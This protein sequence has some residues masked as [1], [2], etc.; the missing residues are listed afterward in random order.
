MTTSAPTSAGAEFRSGLPALVFATL[1][2]A[3]GYTA[4]AY[5]IGPLVVPLEQEFGWN[6]GEVTQTNL[7]SSI[8]LAVMLPLTGMLA[9]RRGVRVVFVVTIPL[10][11][12]LVLSLA[13]FDGPLWLFLGT[14]A[15]I[16]VVGSGTSSVMY[17]K[18][19][20]RAFDRARGLALGILSAGLGAVAL[21]FPPLMGWAIA[22]WGWRSAF[23]TMA[24]IAL[25]PLVALAFVRM[26]DDR[27]VAPA[28]P[29]SLPGM[30]PARA[31]RTREFWTLIIAFFVLGYALVSMI[32][33][34]VPLLIDAG[35]GPVQAAFLSALVGLGTV[36]ARPVIGWFI[37]RF[38]AT[39]V[40][41]PLFLLAAAGTLVL[42]LGGAPYAPLTA[43]LIGIG[44]GAE[45]DLA[46]YLSSRYLGQR[47]FGALYGVI[48][49]AFAIGAAV[50]PVVTGYIFASRGSYSVA[51]VVS[52]IL[53]ITGSALLLSL[54][55]YD[56]RNYEANEAMLD[57]GAPRSTP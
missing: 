10:F 20:A 55:R 47:A 9:D 30:P 7:W 14:Y 53:I 1:G 51:L 22:T 13:M 43:I 44:F 19:V 38:Y 27:G 56:R 37:D 31:V 23:V 17:A 11:A 15:V 21:I 3:F 49:S 28:D 24:A 42:L 32:P 36:V 16:G 18:V 4:L 25:V 57:A 35:V 50:G 41:V 39:Y 8:G 48:Y 40:G 52:I 34:F 54:P 12:V 45:V 26:P 33:H 5:F 2:V 46:S 6:R 29:R